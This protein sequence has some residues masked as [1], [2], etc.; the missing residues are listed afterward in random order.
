MIA[1]GLRRLDGPGIGRRALRDDQ[2]TSGAGEPLRRAGALSRQRRTRL[3]RR[4][5]RAVR[6]GT[7]GCRDARSVRR[8]LPAAGATPAYPGPYEARS[9]LASSTPVFLKVHPVLRVS[10]VGA[11][12]VGAR[13]VARVRPAAAGRLAVRVYCADELVR[14]NACRGQGGLRCR[15]GLPRRIPRGRAAASGARDGSQKRRLS[16]RRS[17]A[18]A[19]RSACTM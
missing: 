7:R 15:D 1:T 5:D 14:R 8:Q 2:A 18:R 11:R 3:G 16:V 10:F 4:A 13:V 9:P 12:G 19:A 17:S 6:A